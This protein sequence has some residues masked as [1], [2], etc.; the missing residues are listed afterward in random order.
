LEALGYEEC[1]GQVLD[2]R[3]SCVVVGVFSK[4]LSRGKKF[5]FVL[6]SEA[7]VPF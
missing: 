7:K 2:Q 1:E 5:W 6:I 3:A 4:M